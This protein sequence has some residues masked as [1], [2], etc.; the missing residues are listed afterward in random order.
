MINISGSNL[1]I[2]IALVMRDGFSAQSRIAGASMSTLQK[3][4]LMLQRQQTSMARNANAMGAAIGA[5]AIYGLGRWVSEGAKF[6]YVMKYVSSISNST[7]NQFDKLNRRAVTLGESTMFTAIQI[8]DGMR[9]MAQAGM[10]AT[11]IYNSM[12][13]IANLAGSTM[14]NIEGRGG[15]AD[16]VT[17]IAK[18]FDITL[19]EKNVTKISD[20]LSVAVNKSNTKLYEFGEAMKYAQATA[21]DLNLTFEEVS[22]GIMVLANA[23]I[24]GTMAGTALENMMRYVTKAAGTSAT[25]RQIRALGILGMTQEDLQDSEGALLSFSAILKK[26]SKVAS[27]MGTVGAQNA[28]ID[29]FGVR[30]KRAASTI[31][32]KMMDYEK[33]LGMLNKSG[34]SSAQWMAG[35]MGTAEGSILQLTSAWTS[36]KIAFFESLEPVLVPLIKGLTGVLKMIN[37]IARTRIGKLLM[38]GATALLIMK[39]ASMAYRAVLLTVRLL[40]VNLG[41]TMAVAS[42]SSVAGLN[43]MTNAANRYGAAIVRA[44]AASGM[45]RGGGIAAMMGMGKMSRGGVKY[46]SKGVPYI[47]GSTGAARFL[48]KNQASNKHI[49]GKYGGGLMNKAKG[50]KMGGL[51]N[52]SGKGFG[53]GLLASLGLGMA[54]SAAGEQS[55]LGKGLGIAAD[56][57]SYGLTGAT[58]GSIFPV[59]G[60][61]VGGV[62]G[63]L[64]GLLW[65][66]YDKVWSSKQEIENIDTQKAEEALSPQRWKR[67]LEKADGLK[68]YDKYQYMGGGSADPFFNMKKTFQSTIIVNLNGDTV[69]EETI[70]EPNKQAN[71][72]I[73]VM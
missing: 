5:A 50:M 63:A 2:G 48:T 15:A 44:N 42:T 56:A 55:G 35:M 29:L 27:T 60:T 61:A 31:A 41:T 28:L 57:A 11:S 64:G 17:N 58:I 47:I 1:A 34:G 26:T 52:L 71:V 33:F 49:F 73:G 70:D 45:A 67:L 51:K 24:Q 66:L 14:S 36:F 10:E 68:K 7:G 32:R 65:G 46:T 3:R 69:Y 12:G 62:V 39:T 30:G 43:N 54:S 37:A 8:S 40:T 53:I 23:G 16:W 20:V 6:N 22:A 19:N 13:A 9:W 25:S 18:A 38:I 4:A 72:A 59:I 21:A